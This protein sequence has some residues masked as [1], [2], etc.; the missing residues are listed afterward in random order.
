MGKLSKLFI[1][2]IL[3]AIALITFIGISRYGQM[4]QLRTSADRIAHALQV[5]TRINA[6][7]SQYAILQA[8]VFE[9]VLRGEKK[10][11]DFLKSHKDKIGATRRSLAQLVSDNSEQRNY[12]VE[13]EKLEPLLFEAIQFLMLATSRSEPMEMQAA[14]D[15]VSGKM[16]QLAYIKV[17]MLEREQSLLDT[18]M[19]AYRF[20]VFL[21][22]F[23]TVFLG[24]F[25]LLVF[26]FLFWRINKQRKETQ[27]ARTF[28]QRV[29]ESTDNIISYFT[30][31]RNKAGEIKDFNIIYTGKNTDKILGRPVDKIKTELM[32]HAVPENFQNG[33]FEYI[34]ACAN[35]QQVQSFE[36][37]YYFDK[38]PFWFKTKAVPLNGGVLTTSHDITVEHAAVENLM[39]SKEQLEKQNLV[40][41]DNRAF[42]SNVFKS[43]SYIVMHF[44]S[45]RDAD[46]KIID[47][48]ILFI[49]DAINDITGDI[50]AEVKH[51]KVSEV[52]PTIF[53]DGIFQN[54]V[55]CVEEERHMEYETHY[56]QG[57]KTTW[58]QAT[59]IRLNDG[60]TVTTRDITL[61]KERAKRLVRLNEQLQIQNGLLKDAEALAKVGSY[62]YDMENATYDISDNFYR[63]LECEPHEFESTTENFK[64]YIHPKDIADYGERMAAIRTN[65][66]SDTFTYRVITKTGKVRRLRTTG[67]F[68][69]SNGHSIVVG[70]AQDVTEELKAEQKLKNKNE[71]LKR[72]NAELESFNRVASHDLQEP[73]RKIQMFISRLSETELDRLSDKGRTYF[74]KIDSSANRMQ[75]LIKYLLSYSRINKSKKDFTEVD[76]NET[77]EKI[78]EDLEERIRETGAAFAVDDLPTIRAIPFQMEQLLNNLISNALKYSNTEETPKIVIDCK[79]LSSK[80]VPDIFD[81]KRK[82]YYRLSVMDNGIGFDQANAEKIFELFQRLHQK[83]EYSGTGIGLAICKKIAENHNGHI[84]AKSEKGKGAT[85]CIYLPA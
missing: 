28:L 25:A 36:K 10:S 7:F 38:R 44:K 51:K 9:A 17:Q 27:K 22:P 24:M 2:L 43:I 39:I 4:H 69:E 3:L 65:A 56:E 13:V 15:S 67:H 19:E 78:K 57:G 83:N 64:A 53:K 32:S 55:T 75:T 37:L 60:V 59:A 52:Y 46:G 79:K 33:V 41:L 82:I 31:V 26:V 85:F 63:I 71:D 50:P 34:V 47:F 40:L 1:V 76:L 14:L 18:R 72:S 77:V 29:L 35:Q 73:M 5:E 54:L 8:N 42:L 6:L 80:E 12:I 62:R 30:P 23:L 68:G 16:S 20:S 66:A 45:I 11:A 48:E 61:V 74:E 81:R 21:T 84:V 49:N 70:V 58:F